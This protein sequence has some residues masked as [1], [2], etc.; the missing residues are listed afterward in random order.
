METLKIQI[1]ISGNIVDFDM[2]I[3]YQDL[4]FFNQRD[5]KGKEDWIK[6]HLKNNISVLS[7]EQKQKEVK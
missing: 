3:S 5:N 1:D 2:K 7:I 6:S 4:Y